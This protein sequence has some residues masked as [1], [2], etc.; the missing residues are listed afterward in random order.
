[1]ID[2]LPEKLAARLRRPLPGRLAQSKFEPEL[3]YGRHFGPPHHD[4]RAAAVLILLYPG[5][6]GWYLPLTIRPVTM[7][8]HAGQISFPGGRVEVG[9]SSG[10]AVLRELEEELGVDRQ[11][12]RLLGQLS[13][14]YLYASNFQVTPFVAVA[15][16]RPRFHPSSREVAELL[17]VPLAHLLSAANR[18]THARRQRG[19]AIEA[20]HFLW[21]RHRIWGATSMIL[22]ELTAV[23]EEIQAADSDS[24]SSTADSLDIAGPVASSRPN[25]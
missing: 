9:E 1:M 5:E 14:L 18:G 2:D 4:A 17:E 24:S 3:S 16:R 19:V 7:L 13:P 23:I 15:E 6:D 25:Q 12:V 10:D 22:G 8:T 11:Q 20:P 21:G